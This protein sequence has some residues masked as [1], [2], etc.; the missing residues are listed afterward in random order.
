MPNPMALEVRGVRGLRQRES[1]LVELAK[2]RRVLHLGC[3]D[4]PRTAEQLADGSLLH[5]RFLEAAR[6]C[7]GVDFDSE[8][9][10]LLRKHLPEG[11]FVHADVTQPDQLAHLRG[12]ELIVAGEILEHLDSPVAALHGL[13][14]CVDTNG[15]LVIT[16]P[17]AF[18]LKRV[19]RALVHREL[20]HS[21]HVAYFSPRVLKTLAERGGWQRKV[22]FG[23]VQRS[24]RWIKRMLQLPIHG[25]I[26]LSPL[27]A[28]GL[29]AE[30]RC[31]DQSDQGP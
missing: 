11:R 12:F 27:V 7:V 16:V 14:L 28:D 23:Y 26:R 20:V 4:A 10:A 6:E 5:L 29:I 30:L 13:R 17:N 2:N 31:A 3:A 8:A 1:Y 18:S 9:L 15:L 22:T 24:P 25:L 19:A 21:D